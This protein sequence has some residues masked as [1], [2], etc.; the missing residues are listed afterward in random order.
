MLRAVSNLIK[1]INKSL[2][3]IEEWYQMIQI[4]SLLIVWTRF[5]LAKTAFYPII[6]WSIA[7]SAQNAG[8]TNRMSVCVRHTCWHTKNIHW[9]YR[10]ASS[11]PMGTH[12]D[13]TLTQLR[14]KHTR[15][16]TTLAC[17]FE[18]RKW[19]Q[20]PKRRGRWR[21]RHSFCFLFCLRHPV[22]FASFRVIFFEFDYKF[23]VL[24]KI[25]AICLESNAE[26]NR[27]E[28]KNR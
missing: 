27:T 10:L 28:K 13:K 1:W 20:T 23:S 22:F 2:F 7:W 26:K 12:R 4:L 16:L 9:F 11:L 21:C 15:I 19:R 17:N 14:S 8:H 24:T 5:K 6:Y 3:T 18:N 25:R